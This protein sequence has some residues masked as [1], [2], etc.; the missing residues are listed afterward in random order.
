VLD[1]ADKQLI[2]DAMQRLRA[3]SH[4]QAADVLGLVDRMRR[5]GGRNRWSDRWVLW[6]PRHGLEQ[7]SYDVR[8][9]LKRALNELAACSA[10][11]VD[12]LPDDTPEV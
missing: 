3:E 1:E 2:E 12:V 10:A 9:A 4:P 5:P 7:V 11:Y 6:I 8:N